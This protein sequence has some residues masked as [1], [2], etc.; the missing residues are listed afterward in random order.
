MAASNVSHRIPKGLAAQ[1]LSLVG[2]TVSRRLARWSPILAQIDSFEPELEALADRDLRKRSLSIQFRAKSRE[3]LAK[4]LPE[5]YALVR[6]AAR[7]SVRM[8]HF[9]VQMLGGI[10]PRAASRARG[11]FFPGR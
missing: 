11:S 2:G 8:R 3:P 6:E 5:A 4:L 7:R 9:E 10:A 1:A